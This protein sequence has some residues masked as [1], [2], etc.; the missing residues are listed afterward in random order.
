MGPEEKGKHLSLQTVPAEEVN[1]L[2]E[3]VQSSGE[4]EEPHLPTFMFL[5]S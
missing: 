4:R 5:C 1:A 2:P 3:T